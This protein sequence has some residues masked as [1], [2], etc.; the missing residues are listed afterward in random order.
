LLGALQQFLA[1]NVEAA[2]LAEDRGI[3]ANTRGQINTEKG[4]GN[5]DPFAI[6]KFEGEGQRQ[7]IAGDMNTRAQTTHQWAGDDRAQKAAFIEQYLGNLRGAGVGGKDPILGAALGAGNSP[8]AAQVVQG[9][10]SGDRTADRN[11]ADWTT[12]N[13]T[14]SGQQDARNAA[15]N[16]AALE[17]VIKSGEIQNEGNSEYNNRALELFNAKNS[18]E[19]QLIEDFIKT[20]DNSKLPVEMMD[21]PSLGRRREEHLYNQQQA[22]V[23]AEKDALRR[24]MG[25]NQGGSSLSTLIQAMLNPKKAAVQGLTAVGTQAA[26]PIDAVR[27]MIGKELLKAYVP[28]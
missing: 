28:R 14:T 26:A 20:G 2:N 21:N 5:V 1:G 25:N 16:E 7:G 24:Q 15:D 9:F 13:T 27:E 10:I 12:Q 3:A 22:Q 6:Q 18:R 23:N 19:A 4:W 8:E 17:R 11:Q